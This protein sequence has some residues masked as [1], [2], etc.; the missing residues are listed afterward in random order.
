MKGFARP[1]LFALALLAHCIGVTAAEIN[2]TPS[3]VNFSSAGALGLTDRHFSPIVKPAQYSCRQSC[4]W[5]RSDCYNTYRIN[6]PYAG[7]R[8]EFVLCMRG[9]WNN[10]CRNC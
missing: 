2:P 7:C 6:C 8:Q 4:K 1:V 9:C 10:I 5:C 3:A